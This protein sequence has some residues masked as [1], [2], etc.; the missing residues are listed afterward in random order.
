MAHFWTSEAP[1]FSFVSKTQQ[2][3]G[4]CY[5][6]LN[7][8][9]ST[10]RNVKFVTAK[11]S[12][13]GANWYN[14]TDLYP[15]EGENMTNLTA[16]P[17]GINHTFAWN[18]DTDF[19]TRGWSGQ[20]KLIILRFGIQNQT[21]DGPEVQHDSTYFRLDYA[22]P[23][24]AVGWPNGQI[25]G[26]TTP[27][28]TSSSTDSSPPIQTEW[29]LDDDPGFGSPAT[30]AW[31][32]D[33]TWQ[34]TTPLTLGKWYFRIKTKD[35]WGNTNAAWAS[36]SFDEILELKPY[37]ISDGG[38]TVIP[39]IVADISM[40]LANVI[41]EYVSDG[42]FVTGSANIIDH[43]RREACSIVIQCIDGPPYTTLNQLIVWNNA[44]T[45]IYVKGIGLTNVSY[46]GSSISYTPT[47]WCITA[48]R[49]INK[50]G[51]PNHVYYEI[52]VE[53]I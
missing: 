28:L 47:A 34:I 41:R 23:N 35:N 18:A 24:Q 39:I 38:T 3:D 11:Y 53:E 17:G 26:D 30:K 12:E 32:T 13:D 25:T 33:S 31:S 52:V 46:G 20:D 2:G 42:A 45:A 48:V 9:S 10:S 37:A 16:S 7:C 8:T 43:R 6:V 22:P 44:E 27:L 14:C 29:E 49:I 15:G 50:P 19:N 51:N 40:I 36:G 5:I 1:D 4:D 21:G